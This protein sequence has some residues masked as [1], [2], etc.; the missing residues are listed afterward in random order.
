MP[1]NK[2]LAVAGGAAWA[3]PV[4]MLPANAC[5]ASPADKSHALQRPGEDHRLT[6]LDLE[7]GIQ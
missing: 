6:E 7:I 3:E 1:A 4:P 2:E 5:S